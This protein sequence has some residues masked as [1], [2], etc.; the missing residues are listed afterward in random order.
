MLKTLTRSILQK[1]EMTFYGEDRGEKILYVFRRGII[2]NIGWF[3]TVTIMLFAPSAINYTFS[4]MPIKF[5]ILVNAFWYL[6]TCGIFFERFLNWFFNVY[7]I[8]NK[9]IID[10]DFDHLLH[11]NISEAPLRNVE[12]ITYEAKGMFQTLFHL[13]DIYIQTAAEKREFTFENVANPRYVQDLLS[14]IVAGVKSN[15]S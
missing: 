12:D 3:L 7:I 8:T 10:M 13:G 1:P 2:T 14:D 11:K 6:I 5:I 9:R 15:G 4:E